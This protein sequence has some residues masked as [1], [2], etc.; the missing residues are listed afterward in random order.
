[1][2]KVVSVFAGICSKTKLL[3]KLNFLPDD[4]A[5]AKVKRPP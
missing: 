5:R 1:M 3:D 2:H 4:G